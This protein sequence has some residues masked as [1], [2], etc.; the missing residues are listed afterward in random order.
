[1]SGFLSLTRRSTGMNGFR[2][3]NFSGKG[4]PLL[5]AGHQGRPSFLTTT[6]AVAALAMPP[7]HPD[8]L[9]SPCPIHALGETDFSSVDGLRDLP[10]VIQVGE[11][12][13]A[14]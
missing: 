8:R 13:A 14:L 5:G 3:S 11:G 12:I 7:L 6:Q 1:M 4:H 10:Y 9:G 2:S